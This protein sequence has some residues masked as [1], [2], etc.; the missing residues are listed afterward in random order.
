MSSKLTSIPNELKFLFMLMVGNVLSILFYKAVGMEVPSKS[1]EVTF[2][3]IDRYQKSFDRI[4]KLM[5]E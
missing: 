2:S 1:V 3:T 4:F 5:F